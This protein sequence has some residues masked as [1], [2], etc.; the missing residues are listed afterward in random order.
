ME[1][2]KYFIPLFVFLSSVYFIYDLIVT[3]QKNPEVEQE[4]EPISK[5]SEKKFI[6]RESIRQKGQSDSTSKRK[7]GDITKKRE[8]VLAKRNPPKGKPVRT[9]GKQSSRRKE[10]INESYTK[11]RNNKKR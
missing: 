8:S 10:S 6:P 7:Y 11:R 9:I 1:I 2:L 5:K 3:Y 4:P